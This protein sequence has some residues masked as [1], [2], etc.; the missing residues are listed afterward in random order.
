M[1][2]QNNS[3][4]SEEPKINPNVENTSNKPESQESSSEQIATESSVRVEAVDSP[5]APTEPLNMTEQSSEPQ[6]ETPQ[7]TPIMP[8]QSQN[9]P[10]LPS[11]HTKKTHI[12]KK[13]IAVFA[14]VLLL[15]GIGVSAA[16]YVYMNNSPQKV[17]ADALTNMAV[18]LLE[19]KPTSASGS[20]TFESKGDQ[21][22]AV[23]VTFDGKARD[24]NS[25][26]SAEVKVTYSGK[27]Y[28]IKT[29]GII[30][31]ED[32][33]YFKLENL[34]QTLQDFEATNSE[35]AAY[36]AY[37]EPIIEK[38]DNRWVKVTKED[39]KDFTSSEATIDACTTAVG[40]LK[41][42]KKDQSE[43][44]KIF[45]QNQFI[46]VNEKMGSE[47]I[48]GEN[49]FHYKIDFNDQQAA[50]FAKQIIE[51]PSMATVKKDCK[52]SEETLNNSLKNETAFG[53]TSNAKKP[54]VELWVSKSSHRPTKFQV[55]SNDSNLTLNFNAQI[56]LNAKDVT[57]EKPTDAVSI[58]DLQS[59]I[60]KLIPTSLSN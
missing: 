17:L 2:D 4:S 26:S 48:D 14:A 28:T 10:S 25:Q 1:D 24:S 47:S 46:I 20:L 16:Y 3:P 39:L 50:G 12:P 54:T 59:E 36:G 51:L 53:S 41:L 43:V 44:K 31:G 57:I 11:A 52:L 19:S 6:P 56:K 35:L 55:T 21:P 8:V 49:S 23:K 40:N 37:I 32:E 5:E 27:T 34:K 9:N 58:S 30:F 29:S 42:S 60:E 7:N 38:I 22:V 15:L 13:M 33:Y 18:D 45:K